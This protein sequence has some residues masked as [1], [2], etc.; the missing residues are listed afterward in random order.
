VNS[1]L[2]AYVSL[3]C[4]SGV[5]HLYL[6]LY[7]YAKRHHYTNIARFF[8]LYVASITIYCFASAFG[9]MATT[10][11]QLKFW[12]T[13]QYAGMP[14]G[15]PLG[16]LF[17]M[18]YLG[19]KVTKRRVIALL[20]IPIVSLVMVATNDLHHLHYRVFEVDPR[21][22]APYVHQEIGIWYMIHGVFTFACMFIA[23]LLVVSR[24]KETAKVYRPQMVSLMCGQLV[25]MVTA[26]IYLIGWTPPGFDPVPSVLWLSSLLYLWSINSS[27][28]FSI[29]PIA[30]DVIFNSINDGVVV[31]DESARL[32]EFNQASKGMFPALNK[33]MLGMDFE[34]VWHRLSG[35]AHPSILDV[36]RELELA[37]DDAKKIY[38]IRTSSFQHGN[39][40]GR[41]IIFTD[42]TELK[43]LQVK[44]EHQAYYDELTQI[45][46]RRAFFEKCE[47]EYAAAKRAATP[48]TI[49]LMDIDYFKKVNDTYGHYV[50]DQLLIHAAKVCQAQ[51][52]EGMLFARY[53]GE[54]FVLA[55]RGSTLAEG[56]A[57]ANQL[58]ETIE[59]RPLLTEEGPISLT[60]SC[61][62]AA[63]AKDTEETLNQLLNK[64]DKALYSAKHAGRN[65]VQAYK[66]DKQ[67]TTVQ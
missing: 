24:W 45:F 56:E 47:Q 55:W 6:C 2:T 40:K 48:F 60:F 5:L 37:V 39:N 14:F 12:T 16:L 42:I 52:K 32:I 15:P 25:P 65:Q 20:M 34:K 57:F 46:N 28:L 54:E 59:F 27:R 3:V 44:L 66:A 18:Q 1:Q 67:F 26:F 38:Q 36:T 35:G 31:L 7:A 41:L 58:R 19:L 13:L 61:G 8:I 17:V 11:D 10:L 64:A 29:M 49:V 21:L 23:F 33:S 4:T 53:G 63:A 50:G 30:K 22:G 62:V 51:M 9:L 43:R